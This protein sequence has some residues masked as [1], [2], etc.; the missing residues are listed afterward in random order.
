MNVY[1][2]DDGDGLVLVDSGWALAVA[3]ERLEAALGSIGYELGDVRRFLVTHV[4]R[5]HYTLGV[6]L[7]RLFG[8]RI[9]V[10]AHEEPNLRAILDREHRAERPHLDE[11][12]RDGATPV[13]DRLLA[14]GMGEP[15]L[16]WEPPDEW[17]AD[18]TDVALAKH[19]LRVV[20]TPG[21]TRGH[22]VFA[23]LDAGL[24]FAGDHVL[25][26]ITPSIGFEA[27]RAPLPLGDFLGSLRRVRTL[28][29]LRLLPAHGPVADSTHG[30]VDELVAHHDRRL[31]QAERAVRDGACTPYE[32]AL[33]LRWTRRERAFGDLDPFNQM[34]AVLET[35][36]HLDVLVR[37]ERLRSSLVD[38]V[39]HYSA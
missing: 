1:A 17:L 29:D 19:T 32:V 12:R 38:G 39:I 37:D 24:L 30:R 6:V 28:P 13:V 15:T 22:V 23:D 5:D 11:L 7:R 8:S 4:H 36:A 25:P 9:S 27:A 2:V 14:L 31:D 16:D 21:H 18:G 20:H 3:Q 33:V 34:L 35:A 26:H 10:G